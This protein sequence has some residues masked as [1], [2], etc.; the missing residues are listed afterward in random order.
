MSHNIWVK[1]TYSLIRAK[2]I[3]CDLLKQRE[4]TSIMS[5]ATDPFTKVL[6]ECGT[7]LFSPL[8]KLNHRLNNW[9][10]GEL[11]DLRL[12]TSGRGA[13]YSTVSRRKPCK[14]REAVP[15]RRFTLDIIET[16]PGNPMLETFHPLAADCGR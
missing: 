13:G 14:H 11:S 8:F 2:N 4:I 9:W 1:L 16:Y 15:P 12:A 6:I 7:S 5:V 10:N 3:C